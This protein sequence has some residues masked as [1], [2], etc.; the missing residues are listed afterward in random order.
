[1]SK[2][3]CFIGDHKILWRFYEDFM[4]TLWRLC[5]DFTGDFDHKT[6]WRLYWGLYGE[7]LLIIRLL[8][9]FFVVL[10]RYIVIFCYL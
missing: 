6:L 10:Y 1:M 5:G 8:K 4:K 3:R 7:T 2:M 9:I